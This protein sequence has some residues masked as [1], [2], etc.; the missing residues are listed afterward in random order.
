MASNKS[1]ESQAL[2]R[3]I[4]QFSST[5]DLETQTPQSSRNTTDSQQLHHIKNSNNSNEENH[6][7]H[8]EDAEGGFSPTSFSSNLSFDFSDDDGLSDHNPYYHSDSS[9]SN[10]KQQRIYRSHPNPILNMFCKISNALDGPAKLYMPKVTPIF[11]SAQYFPHELASRWPKSISTAILLA[12][13]ALW[14]LIFYVISINSILAIPTVDNE[15]VN[16]LTCGVTLDIW[17]GKNEKCGINGTNCRAMDPDLKEFKFKCPAGCKEDGKT[18]SYTPVGD[19][20]AIYEPYIIGGE[21]NTYRADSYIC[22]SAI[23]HGYLSSQSGRC[24]RIFFN[25]PQTSF[26]GGKGKGGL[27][28]ISFDS[29]FPESFSFDDGFYGTFKN[30]SG[31][32]DLR[33][34]VIW[35]NIILSIIFSYFVC[36]GLVFYWVMMILGF[37]TVALGSNPPWPEDINMGPEDHIAELISA[38]MRRFLPFMLCS[39][40][41][42]R[43][44]GQGALQGLKENLSKTVF[45]VG[46]FWVAVMENYTFSKLPINRLVISDIKKQPGGFLALIIIVGIILAAAIGQAYIIWR[47]GKFKKYITIYILMI[48]GLVFLASIP[49]QTLRIHH[50]IL[51]L[52]LLPGV[53]FKTTPGLFYQGLLAGFFVSGVA[54]WDFDSIIQTAFQLN[55]GDALNYGGLPEF[56]GPQ[57]LNQDGQIVNGTVAEGAK[58]KDI[59]L[60][61]NDLFSTSSV[62][63][64]Y[65]KNL[66]NGF[67]LI[68]NDIEQY[69]GNA[70]SYSL[71]NWMTKGV[72][73]LYIRLAFANTSPSIQTTG[74]YTKAAIVNLLT[75]EWTEPLPGPA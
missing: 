61:W 27:S 53:G 56:F 63:G 4:S 13:L 3:D 25:G 57:L 43:F 1:F 17:L 36:D 44:S 9:S 12:F 72:E 50:Y 73:K 68:I 47:M 59:V 70:T 46:G 71:Q 8:D 37:W 23:H 66:W 54:R 18:W 24:G 45:W 74:D 49:G 42:W 33:M 35:I 10:G 26:K 51:G 39:Y 40:A 7:Y 67:S 41:I 20:E 30:I 55:R 32:H 62:Q 6:S 5:V 64:E 52:L 19:Y 15:P 28:S 22:A 69:R 48:L 38:C 60:S 31:C 65:I 34:T 16:I 75:G 21:N 11:K 29:W 58:I 2:L 14:A